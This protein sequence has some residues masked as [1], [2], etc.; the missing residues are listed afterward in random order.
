MLSVDGALAAAPGTYDAGQSLAFR[1]TFTGDAFQHVGFG[2]D[3]NGA[4]W[5]MFSTGGGALPVGLYART[6]V[7]ATAIDTPI[8][9]VDPLVA[10]DYEI[11]WTATEV[12]FYVDGNL[13]ATHA[14]TLP[15]D[16]RVLA[17][18]FTTGGG[19]LSVDELR[20][21]PYPTA[22]PTSG[23]FT[24]RVFDAGT[25]IT[26]WGA[27]SAQGTLAGVTFVTRSGDTPTPDASWS[28]FQPVGAGGTI[29]SPV[30]RYIQYQAMLTSDGT[31]TPS[32]T[33]VTIG[34]DVDTTA[35]STAISA[36]TVSGTTATVTFSSPDA[37]VARFE[38][39][40]DGGA[41]TPCTSP[42]VLTGLS[43]G[44]HTVAVRAVDR[45]G[46]VGT[47]AS[48][49]FTV[50]ATPSTPANDHKAPKVKPSPR[51]VRVS[52]TGRVTFRVRCPN[53]EQSCRITLQL[54]RGNK[55]ASSKKTV[56]IR[57]GKQ[58][59]ITVRVR[60]FV[61]TYLSHHPRLKVTAI[62]DARDAAGN[63]GTTRVKVTLRAPK[64][65]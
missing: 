19:V 27:L 5:A 34:Y 37:D 49:A 48:R 56:S 21:A 10:H 44:N 46:N 33:S 3:F 15:N 32:I 57:G 64:R 7:G 8:L 14:A 36:V 2:T 1:A 47:A 18:D 16:L 4:P 30:R 9:G 25:H 55:V 35:P 54:K 17:S 11:R 42:K 38:C 51:S 53:T 23:T 28:A 29:Q 65:R 22:Y 31:S 45:V 43:V 20:L 63:R 13:V 58:A 26:A 62:T 52:D 60:D 40:L 6:L 50:A 39:S 61:R 24:S 41:Y 12:T 59:K